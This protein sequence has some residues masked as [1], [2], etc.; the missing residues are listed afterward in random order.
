RAS[1]PL[2]GR[3]LDRRESIAPG[4]IDTIRTQHGCVRFSWVRPGSRTPRRYQCQP[5]LAAERP[6]AEA[7]ARNPALSAAAQAQVRAFV[8]G[9][10]V[11]AFT[12][13]R[14]GQP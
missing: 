5:D 13:V 11:P 4:R 2:R 10:L 14:Y 3:A 8:F 1:G 7:L 12:T 6:V 9:W